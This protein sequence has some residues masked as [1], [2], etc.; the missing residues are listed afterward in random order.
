[1]MSAAQSF[2]PFFL[3]AGA[4]RLRVA[5]FEGGGPGVCLLLNGQT[6]FIEKYFE[7]ID[8]LRSRG[9]SVVTFDWRGQGGS[10][11]LLPDR[12][13]AHIED[14]AEYDQDLDT[15]IREVVKPMM[16]EGKKPIALAH[17]M[18]GNI[19]LRRLHD[20][21]EEFAAAILSAPMVGI[22]PRGVPWWLVEKIA[23]RL[24]RAGPSRDFIW[25]MAKRD[26]LKLPFVLQIVTSDAKRY[27]RNQALLAADPE[28]RLNGPTWGWLG[29]ALHA[30]DLLE[31]PGYAET[32]TTQA[33]V[34]GA[35]RDR[36][37]DTEA[38]R[39]F[40][41]RMPDARYVEIAGAQ[42]E[43]LMERDP[44]RAEWWAAADAFL[45]KNAPA[46]SR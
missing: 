19:L 28:L 38:A 6:E 16:A 30:I 44:L 13:K 25:G 8:E 5:R 21:Q 10:D 14:F 46:V 18:G 4:T 20:M 37:C 42:H 17:S 43:I 9:F 7:V 24:N 23:D 15:V 22:K 12:R 11:R 32:I 34:I 3:A 40:A 39:A 36:V 27:A 35:G 41:A 26:Q 31:K 45:K 29:A 2:A 1:M 33:L